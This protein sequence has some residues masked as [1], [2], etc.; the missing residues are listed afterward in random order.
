MATTTKTKI[1][2]EFAYNEN[3]PTCTLEGSNTPLGFSLDEGGIVCES[4]HRFDSM[5]GKASE[6]VQES[7]IV[8]QP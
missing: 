4:G 2:F 6:P 5:P 3:C 8:R 7:F 1:N